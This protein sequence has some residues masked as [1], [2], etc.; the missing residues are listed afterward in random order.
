MHDVWNRAHACGRSDCGCL[1]LDDV[2]RWCVLLL[3]DV[4]SPDVA[5]LV[6][7]SLLCGVPSSL[8]PCFDFFFL[9]WSGCHNKEKEAF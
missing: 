2:T 4:W 7:T 3:C 6:Y 5:L 9:N 8:N 1:L